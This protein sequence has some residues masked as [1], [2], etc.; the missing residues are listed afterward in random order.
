MDQSSN[1]PSTPPLG[2]T[3]TILAADVIAARASKLLAQLACGS[4]E[5]ARKL[6]EALQA[7]GEVRM[8]MMVS[9]ASEDPQACQLRSSPCLRCKHSGRCDYIQDDECFEPRTLRTGEQNA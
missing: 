6:R 3:L 1:L 9:Q 8:G 2:T 4:W 7:Y 5:P